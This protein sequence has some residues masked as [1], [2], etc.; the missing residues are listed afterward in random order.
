[1]VNATLDPI[2]IRDFNGHSHLWD[3]IQPP[4]SGDKEQEEWIYDLNLH[5]LNNGSPTRTSCIT[6]N[7]SSLNLSIS[8][9]T[10][11]TKTSWKTADPIGNSNHLPIQID[12]HYSICYKS[13][14]EGM[15]LTGRILA[16]LL[17]KK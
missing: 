8:A 2:I 16:K 17:T 4:D 13:F 11:S 15:G 12:I 6:G 5:V 7:N 10:L 9:R 14:S 1:M 3:S